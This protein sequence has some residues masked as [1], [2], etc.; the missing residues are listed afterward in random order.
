MYYLPDTRTLLGFMALLE[1]RGTHV[2]GW[3]IRYL[4]IKFAP[5]H[6]GGCRDYM[7]WKAYLPGVCEHRGFFT[8]H[9]IL[10]LLRT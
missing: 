9:P 4:I 3:S 10:F 8:K 2:Y 1:L 5:I 7:K 6:K